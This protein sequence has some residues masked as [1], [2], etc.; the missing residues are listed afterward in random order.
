M[1]VPKQ[2]DKNINMSYSKTSDLQITINVQG[3]EKNHPK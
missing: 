1:Q 2:Y 3:L